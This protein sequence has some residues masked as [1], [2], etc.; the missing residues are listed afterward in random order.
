MHGEG[1][2]RWGDGRMFMGQYVDDKKSGQGIY[3]WADGR[4]YHGEWQG[5][6]QHGIGYYIVPDEKNKDELKIKKGVWA[7]G[8]RQEWRD[9][10]IEEEIEV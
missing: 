1:T 3:L 6:K 7:S 10:L 4:A 8:K 9:D 2:Y 5:G